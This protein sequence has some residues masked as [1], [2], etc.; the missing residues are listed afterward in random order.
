M[1][2]MTFLSVTVFLFFGK[3]KVRTDENWTV[4]L[5]RAGKLEVLTL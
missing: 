1:S 4:G 5:L 3:N 2:V